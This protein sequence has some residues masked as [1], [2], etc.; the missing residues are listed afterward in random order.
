M[1]MAVETLDVG[2]QLFRQFVAS[3]SEASTWGTGIVEQCLHLT[4]FRVH[5]KPNAGTPHY[6]VMQ[7]LI[8]RQRVEG[9]VTRACHNLVYFVIAIGRRVGMSRSTELFLG[10]SRLGERASRG[11]TD[12]LTED[13]ESLPQR[14]SLEGQD[15]LHVGTSG[16]VGNEL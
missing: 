7:S 4:I 15:N 11:R 2:R 3:H 1:A 6:T 12:V 14:E 16:H 13:G 9:Q 8:L 5:P 10:K